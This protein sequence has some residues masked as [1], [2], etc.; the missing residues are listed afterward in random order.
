MALG[1]LDR[2]VDVRVVDAPHGRVYEEAVEDVLGV[3]GRCHLGARRRVG[4]A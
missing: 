3:L 4:P 1:G 2:A